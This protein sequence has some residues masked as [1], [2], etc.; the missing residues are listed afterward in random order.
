MPSSFQ[1]F[2]SRNLIYVRHHGYSTAA[3]VLDCLDAIHCHGDF[4]FGQN[5][6]CDCSGIT[7][8]ER[9]PFTILETQVV[10]A[11]RFDPDLPPTI[12]CLFAPAGP[13]RDL[14]I[15]ISRS[16]SVVEHVTTRIAETEE[17][18]LCILG[19]RETSFHDFF[20]TAPSEVT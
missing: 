11:E 5:F 14:V 10:V 16:W 2:P 12:Q 15:R 6:L 20:A 19:Q 18:A 17:Q 9:D 3:E 7:E 4:R 1:I 8:Y 13:G